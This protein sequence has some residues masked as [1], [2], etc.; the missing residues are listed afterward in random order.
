MQKNILSILNNNIHSEI[1]LKCFINNIRSNDLSWVM[2]YSTIPESL[3]PSFLMWKIENTDV[4][5][6]RLKPLW[7][8]IWSTSIKS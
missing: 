6:K 4:I 1:L 2:R 3:E 5:Y 7:F 8:C